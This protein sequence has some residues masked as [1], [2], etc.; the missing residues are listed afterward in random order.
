VGG[1]QG[2]SCQNG[3]IPFTGATEVNYES[4]VST[5]LVLS[6]NY[7]MGRC[8]QDCP[9]VRKNS[10]GNQMFYNSTAFAPHVRKPRILAAIPLSIQN[11]CIFR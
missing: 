10:I 11:L 8:Y 5:Q 7:L 4:P 2:D 1:K 6:V 9:S 3:K